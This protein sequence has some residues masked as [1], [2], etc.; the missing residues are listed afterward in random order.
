M[1]RQV[2]IGAIACDHG[3]QRTH[4]EVDL[5]DVIASGIRKRVDK[6]KLTSDAATLDMPA[7]KGGVKVAMVEAGLI[8][9]DVAV[10]TQ[11]EADAA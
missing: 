2:T 9:D 6:Y 4:V 7:L 1:T 11:A 10:L 5:W 8:T 3:N